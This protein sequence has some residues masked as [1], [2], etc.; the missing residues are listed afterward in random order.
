MSTE[1]P[2]FFIFINLSAAALIK[3]VLQNLIYTFHSHYK[4]TI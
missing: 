4:R 1:K 3:C 2:V